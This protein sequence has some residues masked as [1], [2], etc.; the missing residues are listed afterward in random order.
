MK[1]I[2]V[3]CAF[4]LLVAPAGLLAAEK[5]ADFKLETSKDKISYSMGLDLGGYLKNM[6]DKVDLELLKKGLEDGF[7]GAEP[8]LSQE[9]IAVVQEQFAAEMKAD[10]EKK[11]AEMMEKNSTEG[12]AFLEA[13]KKKEGVVVTA[14]GLQY[15]VLTAGSGDKPKAGDTV[16]VDYVGTLVNGSEF[17]S[18]IKRGEPAVFTVN[19]VIPGWSEALQL[20]PVGSKY[21]VVIPAELAYGEKGASPV[22]QPNSVLVFEISLIEI[23]A[24][25]AAAEPAKEGS[26]KEDAQQ[27]KKN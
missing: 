20:M 5:A 8:K 19:Q 27:P 26:K 18:S 10:Q 21:R 2:L 9:E 24:P 12:K 13:N 1:K 7:T 11:L 16:K 4:A 14:S 6:G 3:C 25:E 15:E 23:Q 22:I 17:D